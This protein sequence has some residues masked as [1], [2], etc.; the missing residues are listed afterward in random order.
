MFTGT[1]ISDLFAAV[2]RAEKKA[3]L[4]EIARVEPLLVTAQ[5][6]ENLDPQLVGVA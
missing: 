5:E 2:E 4:D 1:L 3:E 6:N